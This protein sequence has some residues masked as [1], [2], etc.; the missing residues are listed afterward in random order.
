MYERSTETTL[1]TKKMAEHTTLPGISDFFAAISTVAKCIVF[2][3]ANRLLSSACK[4][5]GCNFD[6]KL[7][8]RKGISDGEAW[9]CTH[10]R[11]ICSIRQGSFFE[12]NARLYCIGY[13]AGYFILL[14]LR[15]IKKN[16]NH[17]GRAVSL[18]ARVGISCWVP[19]G[20]HHW[21][22]V[23]MHRSCQMIYDDVLLFKLYAI[24]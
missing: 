22:D 24:F 7:T 2:M 9:H 14:L 12:V 10:C 5:D 11:K 20:P 19:A 1:T 8:P 6:M 3:R 16:R 17:I 13:L 4:C 18:N 21:V 15:P 23:I